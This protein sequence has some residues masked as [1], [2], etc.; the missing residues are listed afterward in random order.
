MAGH[1]PECGRRAPFLPPQEA[2]HLFRE[3]VG[4]SSSLTAPNRTGLGGAASPS[5]GYE[6]QRLVWARPAAAPGG[7]GACACWHGVGQKQSR[8]PGPTLLGPA[9]PVASRLQPV[10][11]ACLPAWPG[12]LA[13]LSCSLPAAIP[14][15][16]PSLHT[17]A[18]AVPA[19]TP[20][21]A[22]S[23]PVGNEAVRESCSCVTPFLSKSGCEFH[24]LLLTDKTASHAG[25]D[26]MPS[27]PLH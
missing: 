2:F 23:M 8:S 13:L 17:G 16:W 11:P 5:R 9:L 26:T 6:G 25:R 1:G 4:P 15:D 10:A 27:R 14:P 21:L 20:C 19:G 7:L 3:P 12:P 22:A 24:S 18:G